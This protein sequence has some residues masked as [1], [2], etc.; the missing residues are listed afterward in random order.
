M[1]HENTDVLSSI[2]AEMKKSRKR[3]QSQNSNSNNSNTNN[4]LENRPPTQQATYSKAPRKSSRPS[5]HPYWPTE[6][7]PTIENVQLDKDI[8]KI[9]WQQNNDPNYD[10][11]KWKCKPVTPEQRRMQQEAKRK[12]EKEKWEREYAKNLVLRAEMEMAQYMKSLQDTGTTSEI[13][14][15]R[16]INIPTMI[17]HVVC[18]LS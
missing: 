4:C 9:L 6:S 14:K 10:P 16:E 3:F 11:N 5:V 7:L 2:M 12:R 13:G 8:A 1:A 18:L 15:I 17:M